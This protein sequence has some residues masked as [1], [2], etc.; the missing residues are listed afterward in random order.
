MLIDDAADSTE[1]DISQLKRSQPNN[2]GLSRVYHDCALANEIALAHKMH[3]KQAK[4][5]V[6]YFGAVSQ[7]CQLS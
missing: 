5:P 3:N 2:V 4:R 6:T 7:N 1:L